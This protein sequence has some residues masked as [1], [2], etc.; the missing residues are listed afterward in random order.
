MKKIAIII[1]YFGK[2]PSYFQV[3]L[4]SA[5]KNKN[6]D[7]YIF[8][9][10]R[11]IAQFNLQDNIKVSIESFDHFKQRFQKK[12]NFQISLDYPYKICDYRPMYGV[13]FE[14]ILKKYDFWGFGDFD[15]VLGDL[16]TYISKDVMKNY[17]RIYNYGAL[18]IY[19]NVSKMNNLFKEKNN[20]KDCLSYKYVYKTNFSLYFDEMGGHRY[21]YGQSMVAI[22]QKN[23]RVLINNYCAD[24]NPNFYNFQLFNSKEKYDYFEYNDGKIWGIKNGK[25]E[26]EFVYLHFQKRNVKLDF[27]LNK[28]LF[29]IG[30]TL[31]T[32]N[33]EK[34][35]HNVN[36]GVQKKR[37]IENL[38][39]RKNK[40]AVKLIKQ[41]AIRFIINSVSKKIN[42]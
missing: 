12:L 27:N 11:R 9:D 25:R 7:F 24:I 10:D 14:K 16:N 8:T 38:I 26:K 23:I 42:I 2:L 17:D 39:K 40:N 19:K 13:V 18:S 31:I 37:F 21:G 41:G 28:N 34:V 35:T 30:P 6:Y 36:D 5:E 15:I 32:G 20:Y 29:Y 4:Y 1:P 3:W 33:K 22:R